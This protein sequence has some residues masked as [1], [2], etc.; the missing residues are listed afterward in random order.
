MRG[1]QDQHLRMCEPLIRVRALKPS[2]TGNIFR[3]TCRAA[4]LRCKLR[5]FVAQ[6]ISMLQKVKMTS[7]FCNIKFVAREGAN[8]RNKNHVNLQRNIVPRQVFTK[9]I[10]R[11]TGPIS[12]RASGA[13]D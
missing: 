9:N 12:P 7:T 11:I 2:Y 10:A 8:S 6:Q 3:A 5:C 4:M 13:T 1:L